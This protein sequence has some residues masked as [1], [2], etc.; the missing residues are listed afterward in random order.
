MGSFRELRPWLCKKGSASGAS[1]FLLFFTAHPSCE[2][3][4][5]IIMSLS[6]LKY[7]WLLISR[8]VAAEVLAWG[9]LPRVRRAGAY[10]PLLCEKDHPGRVTW[11][12]PP[13]PLAAV[14]Q[15][16][17]LQILLDCS[18][19]PLP[20]AIL[21]GHLTQKCGLQDTH[22]NSCRAVYLLRDIE[23]P[24]RSLWPVADWFPCP[25]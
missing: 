18:L 9:W 16:T 6:T 19:W 11:V 17:V 24:L 2:K 14:S 22:M 15:L 5:R 4:F 1:F 3:G 20:L 10:T 8:S 7:R 12:L 25:R 21:L 13:Q 23:F